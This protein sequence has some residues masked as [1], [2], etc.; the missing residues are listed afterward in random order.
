MDLG[1]PFNLGEGDQEALKLRTV[2]ICPRLQIPHASY[3]RERECHLRD[4]FAQKSISV[5]EPI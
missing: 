2:R 5:G 3:I 4:H 1:E